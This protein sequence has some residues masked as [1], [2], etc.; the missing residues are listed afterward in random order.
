[1]FPGNPTYMGVFIATEK[2]VLFSSANLAAKRAGH[3]N[4]GDNT[5]YVQ[6]IAL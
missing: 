5:S 3:A 1:M 4:V 6:C 2:Q